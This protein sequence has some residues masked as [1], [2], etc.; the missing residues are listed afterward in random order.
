MQSF[1][2]A[3]GSIQL[4]DSIVSDTIVTEYEAVMSRKLVMA[5]KGDFIQF[6]INDN[7]SII[8]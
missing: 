2:Q 3:D 5:N 6:S 7:V 8:S 4:P 1:L